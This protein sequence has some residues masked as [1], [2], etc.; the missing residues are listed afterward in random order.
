[1]ETFYILTYLN[2]NGEICRTRFVDEDEAR[3]AW[4]EEPRRLFLDEVRRL[5]DGF[6]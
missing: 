6:R 3:G 5:E 2:D 1:M 4:Y